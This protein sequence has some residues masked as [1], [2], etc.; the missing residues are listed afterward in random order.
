MLNALDYSQL[1]QTL[2]AMVY[3]FDDSLATTIHAV[4]YIISTVFW[5][6]LHFLDI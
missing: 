1:S 3:L 4:Q 5:G 6:P 2:Q